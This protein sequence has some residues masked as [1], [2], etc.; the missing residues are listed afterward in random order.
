MIVR[1]VKMIFLPEE[2]QSFVQLFDER[3]E[4]IRN[5]EGCQHLELWKESGKENI[6]FTYSHW[7]NEQALDHYRFS[8][9]FKETWG[10]TKALFAQKAEAWSVAQER[11]LN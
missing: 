8:E 5:F 9:F 1:I 4:I 2:V 7:E 3:K 10:L 11:V 6:F